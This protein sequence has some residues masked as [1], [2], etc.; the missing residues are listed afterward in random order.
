MNGW[1]FASSQI[2]RNS[3][4]SALMASGIVIVAA[5]ITA[6][7]LLMAGINEG[8]SNIANRMGAD[9]MVVP[10]GETVA[11]QFN[12]ALLSGKAATFYLE[13]STIEKVAKVP[14]IDRIAEHTYVETLTNARCCAGQF[15]LVGF[16]L[17]TDFT[18]KPWLKNNLT[19]TGNEDENWMIVGDRILL[20]KGESAKFYGTLFTVAGVLEPTGTGMDWTIYISDQSLRRLAVS[21]ATKAEIPLKISAGSA[22]A[23]L[24]KAEPGA[25]LIDLAERIE[26]NAP[27]TQVILSSTVAKLARSRL[28]GTA[29][30]LGCL[31]AGLW[32]MA[33][34]LTGLIFSMSVRERRSQIGL[35]AAKGAS[36]SFVFGTFIKESVIIAA[37]SSVLGCIF[38]LVIVIS[39]RE[40]LSNTLQ[41]SD[42]L[43]DTATSAL[44]V[45]TCSVFATVTAVIAAVLPVIGVLRTEPYEAIKQGNAI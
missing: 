34:A 10:R 32:A 27:Q 24:I 8:I 15:F 21:S 12:Q 35:L 31:V 40:L 1:Y 45:A 7:A 17:Q 43:P 3:L 41:T 19:L 18:V 2:K 28:S 20:R 37:T 26:Q 4:R 29:R 39:F 42:V 13:Q 33:L 23:L 6:V 25:D 36:K 11:K 38:G 5:V 16:N 9:V 14:G 22:S 30:V 44:I